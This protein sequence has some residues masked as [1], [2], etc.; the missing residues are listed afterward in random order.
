VP[1][2]QQRS[3]TDDVSSFRG[4]AGSRGLAPES[5]HDRIPPDDRAWH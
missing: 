4:A 1:G 2:R 5:P 3:G